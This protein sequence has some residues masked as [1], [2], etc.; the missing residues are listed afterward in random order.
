MSAPETTSVDSVSARRAAKIAIVFVGALLLCILAYL[1]F[2]VPASWFPS[3]QTRA[4]SAKDLSVAR[5]TGTLAGGELVL[6]SADAGGNVLVTLT[7]DF[8][9][10]EYAAVAWIAVDVPDNADVQFFWRNEYRPERLN[11]VAASVESGRIAP[12]V[13]AGNKDW[14]GRITGLAIAVKGTL[15]KPIQIRGVVAKPM[16]AV[17]VLRDRAGEWFAFE[18]W[19]GTSINTITGGADVQDLPLP[20]LLAA[21]AL[22]TFGI[23]FAWFRFRHGAAAVSMAGVLVGVFVG[24]WFLLDARWTWNLARQVAETTSQYGGMDIR[25]KHVAMPDG[26]LYLFVEKALVVMPKEPARVFVVADAAYFRNRAAYHLF[27][28]NVYSEPILNAIPAAATMRAG[29]WVV[30]AQRRGI[31][32][33]PAQQ[34][35]RWDGTQVVSAELK[36]V[37]P[38]FALFKVL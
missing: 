8:R 4:W 6:T 38:G 20:M 10:S 37:E 1:A 35:L 18:G 25:G 15:T 21:S 36:L 31:Q 22:L 14:I 34:K 27:P 13:L 23:A 5:G 33:D 11:A 16:G 3:A 9:S 19:T 12:V 30:V 2:A 32:F 24:A 26:P 7:T 29:D 28:H 17:E